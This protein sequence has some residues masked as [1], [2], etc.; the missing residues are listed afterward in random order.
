MASDVAGDLSQITQDQWMGALRAWDAKNEEAETETLYEANYGPDHY[1]Q[2]YIIRNPSGIIL[3]AAQPHEVDA[4]LERLSAHA[5]IELTEKCLESH[6]FVQDYNDIGRIWKGMADRIH[7]AKEQLPRIHSLIKDAE[8]MS[9]VLK[10]SEETT[11]K[12]CATALVRMK[13]SFVGLSTLF[14]IQATSSLASSLD[15][16]NL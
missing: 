2:I 12:D 4:S 5:C 3:K 7:D 15:N 14:L 13:T 6:L 16:A 8:E 1:V 10:C 11:Q 9:S